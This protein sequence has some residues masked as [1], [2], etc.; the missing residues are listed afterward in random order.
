MKE[1]LTTPLVS[2]STKLRM[3]LKTRSRPNTELQPEL[4]GLERLHRYAAMGAK[5]A[6]KAAR[7]LRR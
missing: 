3:I 6:A 1:S 7:Q 2:G 4:L 5:L